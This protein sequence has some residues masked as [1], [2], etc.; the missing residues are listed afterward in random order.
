MFIFLSAKVLGVPG[1]VPWDGNAN[2]KN[3]LQVAACRDEEGRLP[4]CQDADDRVIPEEDLAEALCMARVVVVVVVVF[5]IPI[6]TALQIFCSFRV[7]ELCN[8]LYLLF[9]RRRHSRCR[10][11]SRHPNTITKTIYISCLKAWQRF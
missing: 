10:F 6:K 11:H 5:I 7:S 8:D 2:W 1:T 3:Y 9:H 4:V